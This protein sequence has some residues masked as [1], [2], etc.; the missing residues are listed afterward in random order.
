VVKPK[1]KLLGQLNGLHKILN[2]SMKILEKKR[3]LTDK[4]GNTYWD[5]I[6]VSFKPKE[7]TPIKDFII[8]DEITKMRPDRLSVIAY[9]I[10][11]YADVLMKFNAISNPFSINVGDI[12]LIPDIQFAEQSIRRVIDIKVLSIK[13]LIPAAYSSKLPEKDEKRIGRLQKIASKYKNATKEVRP[14]N[15]LPIGEKNIEKKDGLI[16]FK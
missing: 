3:K 13:N 2:L 9:G 8:V 6:G 11:N 16:F 4:E 15:R 10:H 5:L 7:G 1:K 12:I 14:T